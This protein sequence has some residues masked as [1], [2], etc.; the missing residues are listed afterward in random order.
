M[1]TVGGRGVGEGGVAG[2]VQC[3]Q[4]EES[5][6][7]GR[8]ECVRCSREAQRA[9]RRRSMVGGAVGKEAGGTGDGG[10]VAALAGCDGRRVEVR[11]GGKVTSQMSPI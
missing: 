8:N 5:S 4:R 10:M 2:V 7:G 11:W 3:R 6:V 1:G 9:R